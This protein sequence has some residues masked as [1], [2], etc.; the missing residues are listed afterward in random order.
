MSQVPA[1]Q[2]CA[3]RIPD[4]INKGKACVRLKWRCNGWGQDEMVG[5]VEARELSSSR[6]SWV[7]ILPEQTCSFATIQTFVKT[8][9]MFVCV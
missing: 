1:T 4:L 7:Q 6:L 9:E 2:T 5:F 8:M 3:V